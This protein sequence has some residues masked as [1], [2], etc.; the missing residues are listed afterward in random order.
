MPYQL[1]AATRDALFE[2]DHT[3]PFAVLGLHESDEGLV[4]R[5]FQP[6]AS[7]VTVTDPGGRKIV[8]LPCTDERGFFEGL[9]PRRKNR[10]AYRLLVTWAH[11]QFD[12]EDAYRFGPSLGDMDVWLL[13]EGTHTR[14]Y[15]KLGTH[16]TTLEGIGGVA[17]AVWAPNAQRVALV[18]DFNYWDGRRHPMRFRPECG[19]WELFMPNAQ[20]G[21][22]YKYEIRDQN[23]DIFLKSDPYGLTMELRPGTASKVA[24]LPAWVEP[25]EA[26]R[27]ANAFDAPVSIYEVHLGSWKRVPEDG[28][29]WLTYR[30]LADQLIPYVEDLGFTHIE[31]MPVNE[32]P[33]DASWGYQPLG[34]YAPTSRFGTPD[35]FRHLVDTAHRAGIGIILDWVP[36]HF[37]SDAHGLARFDGT[38]LYEHADPREGFHQDWN[39]L[40]FNYGRNEVRNYLIG[41]ALYWIERYGIDG[42]RVDAVASMLYRDYSRKEGEWVPNRFGGR[43]NLEAI[44]FL[45]RMN[46][47]V[48]TVRQEAITIAEES[49]AFPAVTRPPSDGGLGFHFKWNMGWMNDTLS[50]MKLDPVHRQYHHNKMTFG[51][52]YAWHENFVLPLSHDEVVHGKGSLLSRMPGDA[53]Q[54]FANLRAYYAFMWAH[55]GKKLLFMGCEFGQGR[56]WNHEASLDWHLLEVDWHRGVQS[57]IRDLNQVYKREGALH[58][59]DFNEEG[60][61][62]I[63]PDD[64]INS[65]YPF[66]R[67]GNAPGDGIV[68]ICNFTPVPRE[69]YRIGVPDAGQ[70]AEVLNTDSHYYCGSDVGNPPQYTTTEGCN[71]QPHSLVLTLPPLATIYLKR[72]AP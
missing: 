35:D 65:V 16:P 18:G 45:K 46:E 70:Y 13:A 56:E 63:N 67:Y 23:G 19:V 50:Y 26:R 43:E 51:L 21:Q 7:A 47:T 59:K 31:L 72:V 57:L 1:D 37:P 55:P 39:T 41:N 30:E 5:T 38:H 52:M 44:D 6:Q 69:G 14:P 24:R 17:F 40:I 22:M 8:A 2:G 62:W 25:S 11:G 20:I 4:I 68:V 54:Q 12:L 27:K 61:R 60:F 36:G 28:Q 9:I 53:W 64:N 49:T 33:F 66:I 71:G 34:M 48:G 10:F 58:Q 15:E 3:D 42:L 32:H 29:R